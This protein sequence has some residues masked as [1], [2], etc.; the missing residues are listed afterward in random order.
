MGKPIRVLGG[1]SFAFRNEVQDQDEPKLL[2]KDGQGF[3]VAQPAKAKEQF[4]L[5]LKETFL[6]VNQVEGKEVS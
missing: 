6:L 5:A 2:P 4:T 3:G 1:N